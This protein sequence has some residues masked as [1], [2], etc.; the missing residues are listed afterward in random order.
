MFDD[1]IFVVGMEPCDACIVFEPSHLF[2]GVDACVFL[3]T[4]Y[5]HGQFPGSVEDVEHFLV[6]YGVQCVFVAV[7][8]EGHGFV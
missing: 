6:S 5:G 1:A 7:G 4:L 8:Q 3:Q 2:L